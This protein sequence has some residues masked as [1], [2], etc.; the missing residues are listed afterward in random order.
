[1]ISS[2]C[3]AVSCELRAPGNE[4]RAELLHQIELDVSRTL[5]GLWPSTAS[6][7]ARGSQLAA[8]PITSAT[9]PSA[10]IAHS[11]LGGNTARADRRPRSYPVLPCVAADA[12]SSRPASCAAA[13]TN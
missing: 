2:L 13:R 12:G 10:H 11:R 5:R 9:A 4:S 6:L 7:A 8:I 1:M 3:K